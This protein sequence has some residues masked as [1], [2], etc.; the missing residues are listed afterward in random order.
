MGYP[1]GQSDSD[2]TS[3]L[4]SKVEAVNDKD[5]DLTK[6]NKLPQ[7]SANSPVNV[8]GDKNGNDPAPAKLDTIKDNPNRS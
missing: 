3:T 7:D 8:E 1:E 5:G 6:D 4:D 2:K